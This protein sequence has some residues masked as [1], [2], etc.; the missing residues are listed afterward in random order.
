MAPAHKKC[1]V[2]M[3]DERMCVIILSNQGDSARKIA[4][5]FVCNVYTVFI[6]TE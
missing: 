5:S 1:K 3:L 6:L 2:M 4:E